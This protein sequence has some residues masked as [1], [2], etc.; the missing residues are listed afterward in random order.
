M[1]KKVLFAIMLLCLALTACGKDE[2]LESLEVTE[3]ETK[4]IFDVS[5]DFEKFTETQGIEKIEISTPSEIQEVQEVDAQLET[6]SNINIQE[7]LTEEQAQY[8]D[9]LL[10]SNPSKSD[11]ENALKS[12]VFDTLSLEEKEEVISEMELQLTD[13]ELVDDV[14]EELLESLLDESNKKMQNDIKN[15]ELATFD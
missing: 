1:K 4:S 12:E 14:D 3:A 15:G 10:S 8:I 9:I 13:D 5:E 2:S 11:L 6:V 7:K